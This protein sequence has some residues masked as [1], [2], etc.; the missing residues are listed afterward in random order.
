MRDP[1]GSFYTIKDNFI[2]YVKT[3]FG[4]RFPVMEHERETLLKTDKIFYREPWIE[5]LPD[6]AS[7]G[8]KVSDLTPDDL[9]GMTVAQAATFKGLVC[10]GLFPAGIELYQHQKEMLTLALKG[11]NCVITSGTGSGKTESFLLPLF[12]QLSKELQSWTKPNKPEDFQSTWWKTNQTNNIVD[13]NFQLAK[14]AQQRGHETRPAAVRALILYPMN[15]LVEDQMTRLRKALD[16][17]AARTWFEGNANGN[18]IYFGR[19]NSN[20]PVA[21]ELRKW[22]DSRSQ[23]IIHQKKVKELCKQLSSIENAAKKVQEFI[24]EY[25]DRVDDPIELTAFFQR[26]DRTEMRCR[27]D[28]QLSPPDILITN[29]SMLSIMMMREVDSTIF[30]KT[31]AWLACEDLPAEER[32]A[33]RPNRIFHLIIDELHLYRG[34]S[35]T[36]VAYLVRLVLQRLGL[37]PDHPQLRILASSAS[38]DQSKSESTQFLKD[39]FGTEKKPFSIVEGVEKDKGK[40][41]RPN[42]LLPVA[43]FIGITEAFKLAKGDIENPHFIQACGETAQ[44]LA[45]RYGVS[46]NGETGIERLRQ[47]LVS[48][49][50]QLRERLYQACKVQGETKAVCVLRKAGDESELPFFSEG[51]FG[52]GLS[53]EVLRDAMRGLLI[54]RSLVEKD[55]SLPRFRFHWFFRNIEGMWAS[56]NPADVEERYS[57]ETRPIGRLFGTSRIKSEAGFRVLELL[58]CDNCGTLFVGGNRLAKQDGTYELLALSPDIEGIPERTA[59]QLLERRSYQEFAVFWAKGK[60]QYRQHLNIRGNPKDEWMQPEINNVTGSFSAKW[61][62]ALINI[63]SGD[64]D[65]GLKRGKDTPEHWLEGMLFVVRENGTD[66]A[67]PNWLQIHEPKQTHKALPCV[68]PACGVNYA[69]K[70]RASPVR[71]F[72]TGFAKTNQMLAK[73]LVYQLPEDP[74][75]RKLVV[76]SDSR[77]DAAQVAN[78]I[79][80]LH[81]DDLMREILV[82]QIQARQNILTALKNERKH[83]IAFYEK[84]FKGDFGEIKSNF[85]AAHIPNPNAINAL[86][87]I[88][89]SANRE[90]EKI[91]QSAVPV[92]SLIRYENPSTK[93]APPLVRRFLEIGVNP[94]GNDLRVQQVNGKSWEK[95]FDFKNPISWLDGDENFF[96]TIRKNLMSDLTRDTFFG[97]LHYAFEASGFGYLTVMNAQDIALREGQDFLETLQGVIRMLG[98]NYRHEYS[99]FDSAP[100]TSFQNFSARIRR[101]VGAINDDPGFGEKIYQVLRDTRALNP[102]GDLII[103]NLVLK[104]AKVNDPVW[105]CTNCFRPHLHRSGGHC[106][107]CNA[108]IPLGYVKNVEELWEKGYHAYHAAIEKRKPIRLH[109]E[110]LTGQTDDQFER[111]RHFRN[112]ILEDEGEP[113]VRTIDLLSVTTT[114]EVGVDIGS[115]QAVMLGNMP[116]Q[117]F[118]YQQRVGRAGRRGQAYSVTLTFCRGRSHDEFYFANPHKITGDPPPVPFLS[119]KQ[120]RIFYRL[121]AKEVLRQAFKGCINL[122]ETEERG[123]HGEFGEAR[124]WEDRKAMLEDWARQNPVLTEH[125]IL[126]LKKE[127]TPAKM[128]EFKDWTQSALF[129]R[130]D[131]I[132]ANSEIVSSDLA[133]KLAEGGLLPM[134]GMPTSVRNLYHGIKRDEGGG[135]SALSIDRDQGL[136]I[137]EFA[138]G[139]QKTKDKAIHTSIGFTS[140]FIPNQLGGIPTLTNKE[141]LSFSLNRWMMLCKGCGFNETKP[142]D[143]KPTVTHCPACGESEGSKFRVFNIKAPLAYRTNLTSGK[144]AKEDSE[145]VLSRPP[146]YAEKQDSGN[147]DEK[148]VGNTYLHI[149]DNDVTWRINTNGDNLFKGHLYGNSGFKNQGENTWH[150]FKNQWIMVGAENYDQDGFKLNTRNGSDLETIALAANKKTEILRISPEKVPLELDLNMFSHDDPSRAS[151]IKGAFYSA[152]FLLQR[153]LADRLD[154]DPTEIEIADIT[155]K[156]LANGLH[157]AEI[158]LTDELPNGSG[159]V[160]NLHDRYAEYLDLLLQNSDSASYTGKLRGEEH[161]GTCQD[162]CYECLKVYRNMNYH[163]LLDWRLGLGL[164]RVMA[165]PAYKAGTDGNFNFPELIGWLDFAQKLR[166]NFSESF[167]FDRTDETVPLPNFLEGRRRIVL[168][169]HPFWDC[170]RWS[171]DNWLT[172]IVANVFSRYELDNVKFVDT[173][174]LHRRPAWCYEKLGMA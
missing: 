29:F 39:F 6:Y 96:Q 84:Q 47:A 131:E 22:D 21:G 68:C 52:E 56:L 128:A 109:C 20:S 138:P 165:N 37:H 12:A 157:T 23:W 137:F 120:E 159:F 38:L 44:S 70:K 147:L 65:Y 34:T 74:K 110:E 121:L 164:L 88:I 42:D 64:I 36:E 82:S 111:Q 17:E 18:C 172:E 77:E 51:L 24:K 80:R 153:T 1:L 58:Y 146:I 116:P 16:S 108:A 26:L 141:G 130:V 10:Q 49:P 150:N 33:E 169:M 113:I 170:S 66:V 89:D 19:Y 155:R 46:L 97:R 55:T 140:D 27:F 134:Y 7:S 102:N 28:M 60:Q 148:T 85:D 107:Y 72:R 4:T 105:E 13:A 139:S 40:T 135:Y 53:Y 94:G 61:E 133:Q 14:N 35:G 122:H 41:S 62:N 71:G 112:V 91:E 76:F 5:P 54:T 142:F 125:I 115:L 152:A 168:I 99:E 161:T 86:Q 154:V 69:S 101:Y 119:M 129:S 104:V 9:P 32:V 25:P 81:Y 59:A 126:A 167:G 2:R 50:V 11:E 83:E 30:D 15:A 171:E 156:T 95:I 127:A 151:S 43:P 87:Q 78:G 48:A 92:S 90:L 31:K 166:V 144:D 45:G 163:G 145:L 124:N 100:W 162:A 63:Y 123:V 160:R 106:T 173:F 98:D 57:G 114:L 75:Q 93:L 67:N 103:E 79:E 143:E 132:V 73:E 118:N 136:A 3:A 158:V 117:R 174:N 8:K 149:S